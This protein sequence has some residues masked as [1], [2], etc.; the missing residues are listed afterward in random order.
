MLVAFSGSIQ[1]QASTRG[2]GVPVV[3]K[4]KIGVSLRMYSKRSVAV[5]H[6]LYVNFFEE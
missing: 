6:I 1:G 4:L 5:F 3:Y 2:V